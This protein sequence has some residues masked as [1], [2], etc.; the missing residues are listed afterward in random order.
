MLDKREAQPSRIQRKPADK[1][2][3]HGQVCHLS[4]AIGGEA[5]LRAI[6]SRYSYICVVYLL[7]NLFIYC[8]LVPSRTRMRKVSFDGKQP[9]EH[10]AI[11]KG[12]G[13]GEHALQQRRRTA[14]RTRAP[15]RSVWQLARPCSCVFA[16]PS[17]AT[18]D[19]YHVCSV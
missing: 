2:E 6:R 16:I 4:P 3:T 17:R 10:L 8:S 11:R 19:A 1:R 13:R 14:S 18:G 12:S 5:P 9:S 7:I 15:F